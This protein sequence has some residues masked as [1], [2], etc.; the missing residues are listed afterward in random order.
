MEIGKQRFREL[1]EI[2]ETIPEDGWLN[3]D[4]KDTFLIQ[5]EK[6]AE[7]GFTN[8]EISDMLRSLYEAIFEDIVSES[9]EFEDEEGEEWKRG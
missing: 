2:I 1:E 5:A 3:D 7:R 6:L 8:E 4:S 9:E